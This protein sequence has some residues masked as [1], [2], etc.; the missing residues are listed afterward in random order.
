MTAHTNIVV[1]HAHR[2]ILKDESCV[3]AQIWEYELTPYDLPSNPCIKLST[4][5]LFA[6]VVQGHAMAGLDAGQGES[7]KVQLLK[8]I[9]P[10]EVTWPTR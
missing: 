7:Q 8:Y 6:G 1:S 3:R 9:L 10:N 4:L 2:F 5:S